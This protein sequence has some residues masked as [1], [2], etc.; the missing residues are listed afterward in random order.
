MSI[1]HCSLYSAEK[2]LRTSYFKEKYTNIKKKFIHTLQKLENL[3]EIFLFETKLNKQ[4]SSLTLFLKQTI[5]LF[6]T[7]WQ[8][9]RKI[10]PVRKQKE[11]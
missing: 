4:Y 1:S 3:T 10:K 11:F 8:H 7:R 6:F 9:F 2:S 5:V